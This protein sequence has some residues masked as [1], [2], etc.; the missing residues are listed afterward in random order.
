MGKTEKPR[1]KRTQVSIK[2][3]TYKMLQQEAAKRGCKVTDLVALILEGME[4]RSVCGEQF[5]ITRTQDGPMPE[6]PLCEE[7]ESYARGYKAGLRD[8]KEQAK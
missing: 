2:D 5:Y 1:P 3:A 6:E 4:N 7:C 8:G